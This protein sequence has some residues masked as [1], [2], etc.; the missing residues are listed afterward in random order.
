VSSEPSAYNLTEEANSQ[1]AGF[2]ASPNQRNCIAS[3]LLVSRAAV[4]PARDQTFIQNLSYPNFLI[5]LF[6]VILKGISLV[7]LL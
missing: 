6:L 5:N 2:L 4:V 3:R 1:P 7:I